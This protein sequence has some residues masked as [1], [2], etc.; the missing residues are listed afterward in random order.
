M[1]LPGDFKKLHSYDVA[2]F[3]TEFEKV[4]TWPVDAL[5]A[6]NLVGGAVAVG[7]MYYVAGGWPGSAPCEAVVKGYLVGGLAYFGVGMIRPA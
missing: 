5:R 4:L 3:P 2:W 7:V 6:K 1:S